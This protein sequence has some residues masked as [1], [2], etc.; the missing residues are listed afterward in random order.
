VSQDSTDGG[1]TLPWSRTAR[2]VPRLVVQPLQSFLRQEQ[3]GALLL[4]AAVA[5]ALVWANSPWSASYQRVWSTRVSIAAGSNVLDVDLRDWV[6]D[7]LMTLF[8]FVVGLE[9]KRELV[10][11]ELR[12]PREAILPALAAVGGMA[13]PA[14]IYVAVVGREAGGGWGIAM[15]TDIALALGVLSLAGRRTPS[16]LKAFL[17][18][19]AIVDDLGSILV[20]ALFYT[21]SV[22]WAALALAAATVGLVALLQR[23]DVRATTVYVALGVVLWIALERS[24]ATPTLAG[25]AIA[26][27]VPARPHNRPRAVSE[28]AHRIADETVDDPVPPDAD[29]P[30]W[31][32][33]ARLSRA[34]VSPLARAEGVLHP[35]TSFVVL[36]LFALANAGVSLGAGQLRGALGSRIGIAILLAR[37]LGKPL[38]IWLAS[39][40]CV[41]TGLARLPSGVGLRHVAAVGAAAGVPFAVSLFVARLALPASLAYDATVG[42]LGA[43]VVAGVVGGFALRRA[44]A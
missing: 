36:P 12:R 37:V 39:A 10:T 40:I 4:I 15:P 23:I 2:P 14:L 9:I 32:E 34:A 11:G 1:I 8:F 7:G 33:L 26:L 35:W 44:A 38:G 17:L 28:E 41:R 13:V 3:S 5:V 42:V 27:L 21:A 19:L 25:V 29:A 6:N 16:G 43:A 30:Q 31:L 22:D 24:G 20:I 18:A